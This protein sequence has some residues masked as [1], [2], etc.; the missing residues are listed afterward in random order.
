MA[1]YFLQQNGR[2]DGRVVFNTESC[3]NYILEGGNETIA[4]KCISLSSPASMRSRRGLVGDECF[5]VQVSAA[6]W[7][8]P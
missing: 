3:P 6:S 2:V 7:S 5:S 8:H 4:R 1:L